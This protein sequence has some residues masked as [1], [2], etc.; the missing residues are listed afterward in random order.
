[1]LAPLDAAN[2]IRRQPHKQLQRFG[3]KAFKKPRSR[4]SQSTNFFSSLWAP[5]SME[6]S[7]SVTSLVF[8]WF[9]SVESDESQI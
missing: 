2:S 6:A 5:G 4:V 7:C 8:E 1:M 9:I 3:C